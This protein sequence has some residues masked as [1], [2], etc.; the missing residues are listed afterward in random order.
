DLPALLTSPRITWNVK[1]L[2]RF[3]NYDLYK[4]VF[5]QNLSLVLPPHPSFS[6]R[7][8]ACQYIETIHNQL[9]E[10]IIATLGFV[11]GRRP[12]HTDDYLKGFWTPEMTVAFNRKEYL[13]K[14]WRKARGL[15]CLRYW[16]Q[17]QTAQATLRRL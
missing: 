7:S 10:S 4:K 16:E 12:P 13:Y 15:N 2:K 9:C 5:L 11:C 8:T 17:H 3:E 6:D 14:K 1:K